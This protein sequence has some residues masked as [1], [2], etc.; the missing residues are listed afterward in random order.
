MI[1]ALRANG[2]AITVDAIGGRDQAGVSLSCIEKVASEGDQLSRYGRMATGEKALI[3]PHDH[4]PSW[5]LIRRGGGVL[6]L[7]R[8]PR[9]G[10]DRVIDGYLTEPRGREVAS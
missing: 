8:G 1:V 2:T 9:V 3:R 5:W 7:R 10:Y 6:P 4:L